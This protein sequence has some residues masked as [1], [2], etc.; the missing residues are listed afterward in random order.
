MAIVLVSLEHNLYPY[1]HLLCAHIYCMCSWLVY[2]NDGLLMLTFYVLIAQC[3]L[4]M[5]PFISALHMYA[6]VVFTSYFGF[7][8]R[9][10]FLLEYSQVCGYI[11][12]YACVY[13][14]LTY[15]Y[16]PILPWLISTSSY[17]HEPALVL[18]GVN[19]L[20]HGIPC[21]PWLLYLSIYHHDWDSSFWWTHSSWFK[22]FLFDS[23]L[24]SLFGWKVF[25]T[26]FLSV[27]LKTSWFVG[28]EAQV[29]LPKDF[30][31]A[32]IFIPWRIQ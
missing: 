7:S 5:L 20:Y 14:P 10:V 11:Y 27:Q 6:Y 31:S 26:G 4:W 22:F 16:S 9:L 29:N 1:I 3:L 18:V 19:V 30:A 32:L 21:L 2:H 17:I 25:S 15:M 13:L 23:I 24:P 28:R 8:L 12:A